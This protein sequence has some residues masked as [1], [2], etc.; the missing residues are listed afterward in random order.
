[1]S[2][3]QVGPIA[4][5]NSVVCVENLIS[6]TADRGVRP[7]ARVAIRRGPIALCLDS[8]RTPRLWRGGGKSTARATYASG[9]FNWSGTGLGVHKY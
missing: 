4:D 6:M 5:T 8:A 1:M 7:P 3:L 9:K 2:A